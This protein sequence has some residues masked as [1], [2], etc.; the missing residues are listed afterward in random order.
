MDVCFDKVHYLFGA[1]LLEYQET[2]MLSAGAAT[3]SAVYVFVL[4]YY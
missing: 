3:A 1:L 2:K 4:I